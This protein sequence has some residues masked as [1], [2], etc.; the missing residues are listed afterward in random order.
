M[1]SFTVGNTAEESD[2]NIG[3]LAP[4]TVSKSTEINFLRRLLSTTQ[5]LLRTASVEVSIPTTTHNKILLQK[6]TKDSYNAFA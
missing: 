3:G 1:V 4:P 2:P 6:E 5:R